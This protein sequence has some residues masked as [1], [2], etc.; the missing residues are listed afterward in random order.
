MFRKHLQ[1]GTAADE[2]GLA[3]AGVWVVLVPDLAHRTQDRLYKTLTTDQ[4]G[5]FDL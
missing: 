4:Y 5:R 3:A 1:S 2:D